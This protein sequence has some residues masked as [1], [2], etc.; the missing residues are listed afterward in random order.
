MDL[1]RRWE[2]PESRHHEIKMGEEGERQ[3]RGERQGRGWAGEGE[4]RET[5]DTGTGILQHPPPLRLRLFSI[6]VHM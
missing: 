1:G 5:K 6:P 3:R 4:R 2:A